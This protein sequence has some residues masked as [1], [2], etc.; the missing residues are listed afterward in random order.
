MEKKIIDGIEFS[1]DEEV[2]EE[3]LKNFEDNKGDDNE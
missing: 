1:P 3:T 2:S